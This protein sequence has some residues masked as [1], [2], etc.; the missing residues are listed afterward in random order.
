MSQRAN[1]LIQI[2]D[3]IG[4]PLVD[5]V[6][7]A[8][9]GKPQDDSTV[10]SDAQTIASLLGKVVEV[11]IQMNETLDL[12][13]ED[14]QD[15]SLRAALAALAGPMVAGQYAQ[16]GKIP[17]E[18]ELKR[19]QA[20]TQA[21]LTFGDNFAPGPETA[22]R[23]E[24]LAADGSAVD[25]HQIN[26]Q[27]VQAF[28]PVVNA[29][30]AFPFGQPEQKLMMD[31]ADRLVKRAVE[32]RE[33]LM[34]S[35]NDDEQ[36]LVELAVLRALANV[37]AACHTAE[38]ERLT[39]GEDAPESA[40]LDPVWKNFETR[41]AMLEAVVKNLIPETGSAQPSPASP[42][43]PVTEPPPQQ[44]ASPVAP[45]PPSQEQEQE[46]PPPQTAPTPP[47]ASTEQGDSTTG[48]SPMGFFA[49]PKDDGETGTPPPPPSQPSETEAQ[50]PEP[51]SPQQPETPPAPP[52]EP[53][54]QQPSE[55]S[56]K[57][58]DSGDQGSGNPMSFFTK[59]NEED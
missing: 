45:P 6:S 13:P 7:R 41:I 29:I 37:Y 56:N 16:H 59:K 25:A 33:V 48:A 15:D 23:L 3:K 46:Q 21:I 19:L 39:G 12:K 32:M 35:L 4:A 49:K 31:V 42:A 51:P 38:T 18:P 11:S 30:G 17:A 40:S 8:H 52:A 24:K 43:A 47:P 55:D 54:A 57:D 9:S 22:Q 2:L 14:A 20:A 1:Y 53:P 10:E 34:P 36:K 26:I 5:A 44:D 50:A 58:T 28:I 27:Y